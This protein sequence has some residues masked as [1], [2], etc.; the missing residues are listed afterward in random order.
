[1]HGSY[2]WSYGNMLPT[3]T[4][5]RFRHH[6]EGTKATSKGVKKAA[7]IRTNKNIMSQPWNFCCRKTGGRG[8]M[9][10]HKSWPKCQNVDL[11]CWGIKRSTWKKA[12]RNIAVKNLGKFWFLFELTSE[13]N[14][15]WGSLPKRVKFGKPL[16]ELRWIVWGH[17]ALVSPRS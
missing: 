5:P 7:S 15:P 12:G 4:T 14:M 16:S 2:I 8:W 10:P 9:D 17:P 13:V 11:P 1:M 6:A 3:I